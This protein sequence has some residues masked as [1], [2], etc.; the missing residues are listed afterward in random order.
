MNISD[1]NPPMDLTP[2]PFGDINVLVITDDHSWVAGHNRNHE[3]DLDADYGSILSFYTRLKEK[4][5]S[6]GGDLFFVMYVPR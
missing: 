6:A 4:I 1:K 5:E 2:L 3:L